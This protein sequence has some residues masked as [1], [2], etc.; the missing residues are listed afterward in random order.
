MAALPKF[1][2]TPEERFHCPDDQKFGVIE[3]LRAQFEADPRVKNIVDLDGARV[4]FDGGWG[5]VRASN[6]EPALTTRFEAVSPARVQEIRRDFID[7]LAKIPAVDL[8]K[9]GH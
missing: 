4:S 6:T 8:T 1:S 2:S 9:S 3:Q 7:R 5:L